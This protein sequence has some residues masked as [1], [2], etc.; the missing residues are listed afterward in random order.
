MSFFTH[1]VVDVLCGGCLVWWISYFTQ[2]VVD[3]WCGGFPILHKLWW[4]SVRWMSCNQEFEMSTFA[5]K[6]NG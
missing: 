2:V 1:G 4:F 5:N 3:V 6:L